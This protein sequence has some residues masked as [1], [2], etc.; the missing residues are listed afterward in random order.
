MDAVLGLLLFALGVAL[1]DRG[2]D[3]FTDSA[4]DLARLLHL[5]LVLVGL[6]TVG[7]EWEELAVVV[8]ALAGGNERLALGAVI[9]AAIANLTVVVAVGASVRPLAAGAIEQS[10]SVLLLLGTML[11]AGLGTF[12]DLG[13]IDGLVL[14]GAFA[15]YLLWLGL[16][17]RTGHASQL[18]EIDDDDELL[19][20]SL[21]GWLIAAVCAGLGLTLLGGEL[22]VR[23]ALRVVE[24]TS[25]TQ[26]TAGLTIVALGTSLPDALVSLRAARRGATPLVL[27]NAAG[28]NLCNLLLLTGLLAVFGA[29]AVPGRVQRFD[30]PALLAVT[31]AF[32]IMLARGA[33]G[34][35][36]ALAMTAVYMAIVLVRVV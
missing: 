26:T 29:V 13:R 7:I 34:R 15:I 27:A 1:L 22:A 12:G 2:A 28:S 31:A 30:L 20:E 9:G 14:L 23:G 35:G 8:V 25:L 36:Y 24:H 33:L 3:W 11:L 4:V 32:T 16:E 19:D 10:L 17:F 21:R 18:L 6:L 5:P